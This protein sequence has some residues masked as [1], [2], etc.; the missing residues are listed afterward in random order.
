MN[1]GVYFVTGFPGF[2]SIN[3]IEEL[4]KQEKTHTIYLMHLSSMTEQAKNSLIQIQEKIGESKTNLILVKGDITKD[5]LG[6]SQEMLIETQ[7]KVEYVWH[8]AAIYDLAVPRD[9]AYTVNV[10]GTRN[11]NAFCSK[12][13]NLKRYVYFSTAF[14][15]GNRQGP[16]L[17]HELI[18][19]S[20][21]NN[22]YEQTK[23]E[24]EVLVNEL[25]DSLPITIIRPGIVKG[26]SETGATIK[27]DG[28]Y[29]IMNM[30]Q[31]LSFLPWIPYLGKG[32]ALH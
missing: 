14:V 23:F 31:R 19:P 21:F 3:I 10:K 32:E 22:F 6:M 16:I 26:H 28:P 9:I 27:F 2:L 11:V 15:A 30:F 20:A 8:L 29:F 4:I 5:G 18:K 13:K 25:K 1:N 7:N 17:E 24:A 12:L